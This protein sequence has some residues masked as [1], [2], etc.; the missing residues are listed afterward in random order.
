MKKH[1]RIIRLSL[2]LTVLVG[3][4]SAAMAAPETKP[5]PPTKVYVPYEKLKGVFE[6]DKQGVF[7][8]YDEFQRLW[9]AAKQ[10]PAAVRE[11]PMPYL[12]SSAKFT[13]KVDAELARM[14]L[15]LVVDILADGWVEV[16]IGLGDVA[17][18]AV[19]AGKAKTAPLLRV[20]GGQY[21]LLTRGKGRQ[22][23]TVN[24]ARQLTTKPGLNVLG[25]RIPPA[26]ITTL[27]LTIPDENM[28][29]DVEPMLAATT[30]Q[31]DV[32]GKKATR[33]QTFLGATSAVKL[34]WKPKTQAAAD[35]AAVVICEQAQHINV[36]EALIS[37]EIRFNY[38]IRRRGV[39]AFTVQLP[40]KFRVTA[41]D[42][43]N[44]SK[45]DIAAAGDG[46]TQALKVNLFSPAKGSYALTV[47]MELFLKDAEMKVPLSPIITRE[48]LRRT[49]LI[50]VT[51]SPRRSV[52]LS[53]AKNL[54]RVDT[55]RLPKNLAS[56][57][58]V[59]AWRFITPDYAGTLAIGTVEPRIT[60]RHYWSLGVEDDRMDL[61]GRLDY[62]IERTGLFQLSV[63]LPEPWEIVSLGPS[64][65]VDD[66]QLTGK[67]PGRMLNI[68]LKRE[69]MGNVQLALHARTPR[70]TPDEPV[71]FFLP[72]ADP[73]NLRLYSGQL[74]L[75]LADRLRAE[76]DTLEQFQ[77]MPLRSALRWKK[78]GVSPAMSLEF[79]SI[80]QAKP[81]SASFK[82]AVKPA[83]VSAVV[84]RLVNVESGSV[85]DQAL[86]DYTVLYAPVDT[87]YLKMPAD[88]ADAG[89]RISGPDIKERP[90]IDKLPDDQATTK[91]AEAEDA[92]KWA[93]YKVVL[94]SPVIGRYRLRVDSRRSFLAGAEG[95][96]SN[97]VVEP[98]LAAG[99]LSDQTGFIAIAKADTLAIRDPK[100]QN[101]LP[102]DPTN[103]A[104]VPEA[105]Y[106]KVA[107]LAFRYNAP[108][109]E[110]SLPVAAQKEAAVFTTIATGAIIEQ[111][112]GRDGA[113][114]TNA[115]FLLDTS[116]GDRLAVT[117]PEGNT[118]LRVLLNGQNAPVEIGATENVKIVR[119]P[120]SA[121][122]VT[123][124]VLELRYSM[125]VGRAGKLAAP[126]LPDGIPVQQ[127]FWRLIIPSEELMLWFD[128]A[129]SRVQSG[130]QQVRQMAGGYPAKVQLRFAKQGQAFDFIRQ[131]SPGELGVMKMPKEI[132][133]IAVWVLILVVGVAALKFSGFGRCVLV[134][135]AA[136]AWVVIN[137]FAPLLAEELVLAGY[138]AGMIV[139]GL[140]LAH[141]IFKS[142]PKQIGRSEQVATAEV[143]PEVQAPTL[144]PAVDA[145]AE[146]DQQSDTQTQD[147]E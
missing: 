85:V 123:K 141:W 33:L 9:R 43:A 37:H 88:L 29:V 144:E 12:V 31:V 134:L 3:L 137:L 109:F 95:K 124:L 98:I 130:P 91:P 132:F 90:R 26:A 13:G 142:L 28:K 106:R 55:G 53:G 110:L 112:L 145:P 128:N 82:I 118:G 51:H 59:T 65:L 104:D 70:K 79:R 75:M 5:A 76:V 135:F 74:M 127:T 32:A 80:D 47:R 66:H 117:L 71:K 56:Q 100:V 67:G 50:A 42:G 84:H 115:T 94:Q 136:M 19:S 129:F 16:P 20:V 45:W 11:A 119:L 147:E 10:S 89:A 125:D 68:L 96:V 140:W 25:F 62:T 120:P 78:P 113:L 143:Q 121:G 30:D 86:I 63:N 87:F 24:F 44:I 7:L 64:N 107:A 138:W 22:T 126:K 48:V 17:V 46:K 99:K 39:D 8:P 116:R 58:G 54:A 52:E 83:Q 21:V 49:G 41:V 72:K 61:R 36:A 38:D 35:L 111:V 15:E 34:S 92:D 40:G 1:A 101:L 6:A 93:Y 97:V 73:K 81:A 103:A 27:E 114:N 2:C 69:V 4:V 139:I 23:I 57:A 133:S 77:P 18:S 14:Q 122:Q 60:A 146:Q 131:G 102:G 108:P 105:S